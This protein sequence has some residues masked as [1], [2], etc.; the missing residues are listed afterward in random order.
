MQR[1]LT[2]QVSKVARGS[3]RGGAGDGRVVA[4]AE[5]AGK[6]LRAFAQQAQQGF[7]LARVE[8]ARQPVHQGGLV[9]QKAYELVGFC[10]GLQGAGGKPLQPFVDVQPHAVAL[11]LCV[12]GFA[13]AVQHGGHAGKA[14]RA[15]GLAERHFGHGPADAAIAVLKRV[16]ALEPQVRDGGAGDGGQRAG[17][18]RCGVGK[19]I[20]EGLH[21]GG[22]AVGGR[23]LVMHALVADLAG[24]D[25][26]GFAVLTVGPYAGQVAPPVHGHAVPGE[27]AFMGQG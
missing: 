14:G 23:G 24:D 5:A 26:H 9:D 25:L 18:A 10:L 17:G 8:L 27:Q 2:H 1:T 11:Q 15:G 12:V 6:A 13:L 3:S 20:Q 4:G 7:F 21:F 19:P 16:Y 22:D